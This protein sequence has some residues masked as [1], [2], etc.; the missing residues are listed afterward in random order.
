[1][2]DLIEPQGNSSRLAVSLG[3]AAR[4]V[5]IGRTKLYEALGSGVLASF[6]IGSRR[7]IRT[8]ALDSWLSTIE[9]ENLASS[10]TD[11]GKASRSASN[12]YRGRL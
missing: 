8:P 1:M 6:K 11:V 9:G 5:G 4:L 2:N 7:L 3:E 12:S 10:A